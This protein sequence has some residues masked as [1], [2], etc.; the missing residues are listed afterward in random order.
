MNFLQTVWNSI[1]SAFS[2]KPVNSPVATCPKG[3]VPK[4]YGKALKIE[5]DEAFRKATIEELDALKKTPTGSNI[6]KSLDNSGKTV[7]IKQTGDNNGFCK[8]LSTD[9]NIQA[10][11]K[12]GK[13][14]D[15]EVFSNPD[16]KPGG[17]PNHLVLGHELIHAQHN[18]YGQRETEKN[19]KGVKK[20]ELK[21]VGLPPY[22]AKGST[23]NSLRKDLN[24]DARTE[25]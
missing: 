18:A 25:Y 3:E 16:F 4:I 20:E 19:D 7:T 14:S 10:D 8:P 21:T 9:A 17:L 23:E 13:G 1:K 11:G 5:G 2:D 12:P 15:S 6:L 22:P 24:I